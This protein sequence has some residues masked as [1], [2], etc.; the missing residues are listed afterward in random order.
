MPGRLPAANGRHTGS[1]RRTNPIVVG[2]RGGCW[3]KTAIVEEWLRIVRGEVLTHRCRTVV[4]DMAVGAG[5]VSKA[6]S[7]RRLKGA[8]DEAK[9]LRRLFILSIDSPPDRRRCNAGGLDAANILKLKYWH[10]AN[11]AIIAANYLRISIIL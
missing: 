11:C 10:V 4:S 8:T 7:E 9:F 2:E 5:A 6:S 1:R 3:H